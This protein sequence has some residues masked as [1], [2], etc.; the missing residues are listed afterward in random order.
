MPAWPIS[1][2]LKVD[3]SISSWLI[4]SALA[5]GCDPLTLT[6]S[7]W[8]TWRA[9]TIDLDRGVSE[10]KLRVLTSSTTIA[11]PIFQAASLS[12]VASNFSARDL[13]KHGVWPWVQALGARNRLYRGGLQFCP[14]CFRCDSSP[15]L[16]KY[17]RFSWVTVCIEHRVQLI[18]RCPDCHKPIEPHRL[19]AV[20]TQ[21]LSMCASCGF[22]FRCSPAVS[23]TVNAIN[24]QQLARS[25]LQ[26][27]GAIING[28]LVS[29]CD[30]FEVCRF[31]LVI[32]RR[33]VL[34]SGSTLALALQKVCDNI[35]DINQEKLAFQLELLDVITREELMACIFQLLSNL[36]RLSE[37][38][39]NSQAR[40]TC[41]FEKSAQIPSALKFLF[42]SLDPPRNRLLNSQA[43]GVVKPRSKTSVLK[44]WERLKRKY[45]V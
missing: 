22:D 18:D 27:E 43:S 26:H 31:L 34:S 45:R 12:G 10:D 21:V 41:L 28:S 6:G 9:W 2:E 32:I 11:Q 5:H 24:F 42:S 39:V 14:L 19:E 37:E 30:W 44:S 7:L 23:A 17:W 20:N 4:R 1:T 33:S 3:E 25:V 38:L 13:P 35:L 15:F 16:R 40:T 36:Q 8:P 29:S